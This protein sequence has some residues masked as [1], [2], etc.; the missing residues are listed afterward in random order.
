[1]KRGK[2]KKIKFG[3]AMVFSDFVAPFRVG[4]KRAI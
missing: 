3:F 1:M 4:I 2:L